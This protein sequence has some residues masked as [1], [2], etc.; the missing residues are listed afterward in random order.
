MDDSDGCF[1]QL[2]LTCHYIRTYLWYERDAINIIE[3]GFVAH[4]PALLK[5]LEELD[6]KVANSKFGNATPTEHMKSYIKDVRETIPPLIWRSC[7]LSFYSFLETNLYDLAVNVGNYQRQLLKVKDIN[8]DG[9]VRSRTYLTKVCRI[10]LS[11][12]DHLWEQMVFC[13]K[14]R[15]HI[16]HANAAV[17]EDSKPLNTADFEKVKD[18]PLKHGR[19][20]MEKQFVI[21][22][23]NGVE[24]L[25]DKI[26]EAIKGSMSNAPE[27]IPQ[28]Q[29]TEEVDE[30]C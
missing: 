1:G 16:I 6:P 9:I 28:L 30:E 24:E 29:T 2:D 7:F 10:N 19:V 12:M 8:G 4:V 5:R 13:N 18:L 26:V 17:N 15:N 20:F 21:T 11:G 25:F 23:L 27:A 22:F 14:L 3:S